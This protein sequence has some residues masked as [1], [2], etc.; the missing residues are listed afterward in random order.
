MLV[1]NYLILGYIKLY[2]YVHKNYQME[3]TQMNILIIVL[4]E[5]KHYKSITLQ[6][7]WFLMEQNYQVKSQ[8]KKSGKSNYKFYFRKRNENL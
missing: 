5:L 4:K 3:K 8:Q 7:L 6:L 1:N 2:F